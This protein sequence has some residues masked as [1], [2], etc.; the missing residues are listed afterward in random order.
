MLAAEGLASQNEGL[1]VAHCLAGCPQAAASPAR[2]LVRSTHALAYSEE[3]QAADWLAYKIQAASL[4]VA[5]SLSRQFIAGQRVGGQR[6][7]GQAEG[8]IRS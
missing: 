1:K 4:G 7:K 2:L 6:R 3:R 8:R 5:S